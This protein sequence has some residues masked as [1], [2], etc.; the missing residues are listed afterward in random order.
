M[1]Q[2]PSVKPEEITFSREQF[3]EKIWSSPATKLAKEIGLSDVMIGKICKEYDI[4]KPYPGYWAKLRHGKSPK[5][6][7]L[8][9]N[10]DSSL[11]QLIF[12][13]Y[14]HRELLAE[15]P[16]PEY[17]PD[18]RAMLDRA[19]AMEPIKVSESLRK[20][21]ALIEATREQFK[22]DQVPYHQRPRYE[23]YERQ[24]TLDV[25]T[26]K[27]LFPRALRIMDAIIKRIEK[28]G[29]SVEIRK[30][31]GYRQRTG[32]IVGFGSEDITVLR[33]REKQ[34]QVK[35]SKG[36]REYEWR[37]TELQPS[38]LLVLDSGSADS[39]G[40]LLKDTQKKRRI[41]DGLNDLIIGFI[42]QAGDLRIKRRR[43]DELRRQREE[44]ERI[45]R[46]QE[47]ELRQRRADLERR[48]KAEQA[49][50]DELVQHADSW[51]TSIRIREYL[52]AVCHHLLARDGAISIDGEAADYLR[53][54]HQ[55]ADRLDPLRP[56]P[57][58]VLDDRI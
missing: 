49:R 27:A 26:S 48:Q 36:E 15:R 52:S 56:S 6:S 10:D 58:S 11:Q 14:P 12:Y 31:Q 32:T 2:T 20:P 50:V 55:Q 7:R 47:E 22:R 41:E 4:P 37:E 34:N 45:R 16:E 21:H 54:A 44:Q 46:E 24:K 53:W 42:R 19:I 51:Q 1:S 28:I 3:Y 39:Y 5:K 25:H 30:E 29:G 8:P 38:G 18:I 13:K 17:D 35:L 40:I 33:L 23:R 9:K 43:D 57:P